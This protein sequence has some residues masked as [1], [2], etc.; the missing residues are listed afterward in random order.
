MH[1]WDSKISRST[2]L[3]INEWFISSWI[4][5]EAKQQP[6]MVNRI[7]VYTHTH[8]QSRIVGTSTAVGT[9]GE[10]GVS[11][12]TVNLHLAFAFP[13]GISW[14]MLLSLLVL[15]EEDA[16]SRVKWSKLILL[17]EDGMFALAS[18]KAKRAIGGSQLS[19]RFVL[20]LPSWNSFFQSKTLSWIQQQRGWPKIKCQRCQCQCLEAQQGG[21]RCQTNAR[22]H[23]HFQSSLEDN[24]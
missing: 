1:G 5:Y 2:L 8:T 18:L 4:N 6:T 14:T 17:G 23:R 21:C 15:S 12:V 24:Q 7:I 16:S 9:G 22:Y 11:C 10:P 13:K 19:S 3:K 20:Y